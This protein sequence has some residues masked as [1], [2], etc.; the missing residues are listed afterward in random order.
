M[1]KMKPSANR[2]AA[3]RAYHTVQ[4]PAPR[5]YSK[6]DSAATVS[7]VNVCYGGRIPPLKAAGLSRRSS[8]QRQR[9]PRGARINNVP[10]EKAG[11]HRS[12]RRSQPQP[13]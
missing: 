4:C 13:R 1:A 5:N 12:S 9:P 10:P 11:C 3:R 7:S 2:V 8:T 6:S